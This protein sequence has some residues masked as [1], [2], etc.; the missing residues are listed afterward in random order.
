M[1]RKTGSKFDAHFEFCDA[2]T[3]KVAPAVEAERPDPDPG[4]L[5]SIWS[6]RSAHLN[7]IRDYFWALPE[8]QFI[9]TL[10]K[11]RAAYDRTLASVPEGGD[12]VR[13]AAYVAFFEVFHEQHGLP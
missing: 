13:C 5:A 6:L 4:A 10:K 9:D 7:S 2:Y 3:A 1:L 12:W 11:A 8:P